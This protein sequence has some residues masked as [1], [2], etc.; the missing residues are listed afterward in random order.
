[1]EYIHCY[2]HIYIYSITFEYRYR[3]LS[4]FPIATNYENYHFHHLIRW[5]VLLHIWYITTILLS[6]NNIYFN[7][8]YIYRNLQRSTIYSNPLQHTFMYTWYHVCMYTWCPRSIFD[9]LKQHSFVNNL[10][11]WIENQRVET[12]RFGLYFYRYLFDGL[13]SVFVNWTLRDQGSWTTSYSKYITNVLQREGLLW[14]K[15]VV[16]C[17]SWS[18]FIM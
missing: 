14:R 9:K 3:Y 1:M 15:A 11:N 13:V 17:Y 2:I 16:E 18:Y 4:L 5:S 10:E 8:L 12:R 6:N 7:V